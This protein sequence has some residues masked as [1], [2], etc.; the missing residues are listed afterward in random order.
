MEEALLEMKRWMFLNW[1]A[2]VIYT[3]N[4]HLFTYHIFSPYLL[5]A[6]HTNKITYATKTK[7]H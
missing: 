2:T 1:E 4:M 7:G 5:S 6:S 3:Q